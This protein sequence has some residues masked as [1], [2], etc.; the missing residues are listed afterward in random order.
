M[1]LNGEGQ[2]RGAGGQA[3]RG[4]DGPAIG[5]WRRVV[6]TPSL[7]PRS[8]YSMQAI[9]ALIGDGVADGDAVGGLGAARRWQAGRR[10]APPCSTI[11]RPF[12]RAPGRFGRRRW[13][14]APR[15]RKVSANRMVHGPPAAQ[16]RSWRPSNRIVV[17][18]SRNMTGRTSHLLCLGGPPPCRGSWAPGLAR[19]AVGASAMLSTMEQTTPGEFKP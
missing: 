17:H 5:E 13:A 8:S 10:S 2:W 6:Y 14:E 16:S 9:M 19:R 11:C 3:E 18:R 7:R 15:G 4:R 12:P 1:G